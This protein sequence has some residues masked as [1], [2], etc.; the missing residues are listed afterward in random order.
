MIRDG[1]SSSLIDQVG[2][3]E[4]R[5]LTTLVESGTL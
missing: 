4:F 3:G 2:I 5:D 1:E